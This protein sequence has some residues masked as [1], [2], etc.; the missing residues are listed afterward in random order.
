MGLNTALLHRVNDLKVETAVKTNPK[1]IAIATKE[2]K[3]FIMK[4]IKY[5]IYTCTYILPEGKGFQWIHRGDTPFISPKSSNTKGTN[6]N[7]LNQPTP[8]INSLA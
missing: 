4:L 3:V 5:T 6:Q 2:H 7:E 1:T 8:S